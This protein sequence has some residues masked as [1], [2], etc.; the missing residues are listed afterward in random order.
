M[1]GS[2]PIYSRQMDTALAAMGARGLRIQVRAPQ[3]NAFCERLIGTLRWECLDFLIPLSEAHLRRLLKGRV[4]PYNR[5]H[6]HARLAPGIPGPPEA[7]PVPVILG[8][9][10]PSHARVVAR[11]IL[12][13]LHHEYGLEKVAAWAAARI[14]VDDTGEDRT[15]L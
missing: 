3:A 12:G 8:H 11:P 9:R 7:L 1:S 14:V 10:L 4:G 5:G 15:G 2:K 6:P 13:G